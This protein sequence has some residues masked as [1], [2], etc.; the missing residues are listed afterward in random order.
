MSIQ[1]SLSFHNDKTWSLEHDERKGKKMPANVN[2]EDSCHNIYW[3]GNMTIVEFYDKYFEE[4]FQE[5]EL[6][7]KPKVYKFQQKT[8]SDD[9]KMQIW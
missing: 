3:K 4:A 9:A 2:P 7:R 6:K 1:S 5:Q 8:T